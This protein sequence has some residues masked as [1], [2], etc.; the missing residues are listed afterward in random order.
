MVAG[1]GNCTGGADISA[2]QAGD[3]IVFM[4]DHTE[5]FFIVKL[6]HLGRADINTH[7]AATAGLF[8]DGDLQFHITFLLMAR[9]AAF[10]RVIAISS[11][12]PPIAWVAQERQGS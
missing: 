8:M 2:A 9:E 10:P 11:G 12:M 5:P 7:L 1:M 4:L 3:T 6:E